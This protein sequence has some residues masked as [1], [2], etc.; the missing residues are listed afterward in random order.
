MDSPNKMNEATDDEKESLEIKELWMMKS[1][2]TRMEETPD[3]ESEKRRGT[4]NVE[5]DDRDKH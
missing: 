5:E 1:I 3:E 2:K 4:L